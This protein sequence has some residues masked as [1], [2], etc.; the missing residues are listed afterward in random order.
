MADPIVIEGGDAGVE[1]RECPGYE[2]YAVGN[3]GSLWSAWKKVRILGRRGCTVEKS[4][5]WTR[6]TSKPNRYGYVKSE[7]RG[8]VRVNVH[9]LV[10]EA[11]VGPCPKGMQACH[12]PD[13]NR[14]NNRLS[15]LRWDTPKNNHDDKRKHGTDFGGA[16]NPS[17][18]LTKTDVD[19]IRS[20]S[21]F[22]SQPEIASI[23]N[24]NR[25]TIGRILLGRSWKCQTL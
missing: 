10:L 4:N 8:G 25:R 5:S 16:R 20:L 14:S 1:Y 18:L 6:L 11:F 2:G 23:F 19:L 9:R 12:F 24:V 13:P 3:D 15:N 22:L 17:A 7:F 21:G